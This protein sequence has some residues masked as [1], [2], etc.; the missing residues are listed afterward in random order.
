MFLSEC[1]QVPHSVKGI[2]EAKY[3]KALQGCAHHTEQQ[4]QT[5]GRQ[6]DGWLQPAQFISRVTQITSPDF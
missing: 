4:L 6:P 3:S 5:S 2:D 1:T